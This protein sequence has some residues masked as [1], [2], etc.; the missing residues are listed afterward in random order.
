MDSIQNQVVMISGG[1]K[2]I[3]LAIAERLG[4][5]GARISLCARGA[6]ALAQ[7]Q[8]TLQAQGIAVMATS[9]D[10]SNEE[11][12]ERWFT[13][14]ETMFGPAHILIPSCGVSGYGDL[15]ELTE[16][17]FDQTFS[18][19]MRGAFLCARRAIPSMIQNQSGKI[20]FLSSIASK[21]YR[22]GHSLYFATKWALNGFAF[23]LAKELNEHHIHVHVIAPGMV[24]THFFDNAGRP[25]GPE[26][27]YLSPDLVADLAERLIRLPEGV[28]TLDWTIFPSW[29]QHSLGIR[30]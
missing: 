13:Q 11:E 1:S 3:G 9:A 4:K 26:V 10:V 5:Q 29:Q 20:I 21:Y 28:D 24:E 8:K 12:V 23:S 19:N 18:V 15:T 2:G 22:H 27:P 17:Q 25:H 30:R 16:A 7:A 14:T 6:E